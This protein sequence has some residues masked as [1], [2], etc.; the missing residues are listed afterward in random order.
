MDKKPL[1]SII[2]PTLNSGSTISNTLSCLNEQI[3]RNIELVV[4]D[5]GSTDRTLELIENSGLQVV[6][7][8]QVGRGIWGAINESLEI[9]NGDFLFSLNSDDLI[10]NDAIRK[11]VEQATSTSADCL[12]LPTYSAGGF[13]NTLNHERRWLG[14]DRVT[15]GHSA[16]FFIT[17]DFQSRLGKYDERIRFCADHEL[18][19][20]ALTIGA[21]MAI[22]TDARRSFGIFTHG[23]FSASNEYFDKVVEEWHFRKVGSFKDIHDF[24]FCAF[25]APLKLTWSTIKWARHY[26][27]KSK[28]R[29]RY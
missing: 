26:F 25:I 27:F 12:W 4:V 18:F 2:M 11:L 29:S 5:G 24:I 9:A 23:G 19:Y 20:R 15:P 22:V 7:K 1:V 8:R 21:R 28:I 17:S 14:M 10:S 16:S 3:Y 6:I 13:K